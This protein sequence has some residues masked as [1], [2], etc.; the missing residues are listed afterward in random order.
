MSLA[1]Q[2]EIQAK[3]TVDGLLKSELY[4]HRVLSNFVY[5]L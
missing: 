5:F 2:V 1:K 3:S 4:F